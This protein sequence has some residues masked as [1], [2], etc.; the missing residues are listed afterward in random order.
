MSN[1][2]DRRL[3]QCPLCGRKY[4]I[5]VSADGPVVCPEC[6][7]NPLRPAQGK[8]APSGD[9]SAVSPVSPIEKNN[10]GDEFPLARHLGFRF[11]QMIP[12]RWSKE[13]IVIWAAVVLIAFNCL[14]PPWMGKYEDIYRIETKA[15]CGHGWIFSPPSLFSWRV[16][17][18]RKKLASLEARLAYFEL[19]LLRWRLLPLPLPKA[20][21]HDPFLP[22]YSDVDVDEIQR[23]RR[24]EPEQRKEYERKERERIKREWAESVSKLSLLVE[25]RLDEVRFLVEC[26]GVLV[27]AGGLLLSFRIKKPPRND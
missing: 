18:D 14:R 9:K 5:P 10:P 6:V 26:F 7:G 16:F 24:M 13:Q 27:V 20:Y 12:S 22:P 11:R 19:K 1:P 21:S 4:R 17:Q 15:S 23:Y 2:T 3:W 8:V 25:I